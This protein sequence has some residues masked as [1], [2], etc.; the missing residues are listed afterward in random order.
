MVR[1]RL[2]QVVF[3]PVPRRYNI[4]LYMKVVNKFR[5]NIIKM[6]RTKIFRL[7]LSRKTVTFK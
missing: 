4:F 2:I 3:I 5:K 7:L 1:G 6:A